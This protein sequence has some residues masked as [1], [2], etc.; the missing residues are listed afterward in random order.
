MSS[1]HINQFVCSPYGVGVISSIRNI[2]DK[3]SSTFSVD[4]PIVI[5]QSDPEASDTCNQITPRRK[6]KRSIDTSN[7]NS[8]RNIRMS[9]RHVPKKNG[10]YASL[11]E[12][13]PN[14][15]D[16]HINDTNDNISN[17]NSEMNIRFTILGV[18]LPYGVAYL[19]SNCVHS[20]DQQ[21]LMQIPSEN[22]KSSFHEILNTDIYICNPKMLFNDNIINFYLDKIQS[23]YKQI[24]IMNTFFYEIIRSYCTSK[25]VT[26]QDKVNKF[27]RLSKNIR[28]C[29]HLLIPINFRKHWSL[30]IVCNIH[31]LKS[32]ANFVSMHSDEASLKIR[33]L[34]D[35]IL[36]N[37]QMK[38][39]L[40]EELL[41]LTPSGE[42]LP[43]LLLLDSA[44]CHRAQQIFANIREFLQL[45]IFGRD[46]RIQTSAKPKVKKEIKPTRMEI[47][48]LSLD[49]DEDREVSFV[50]LTPE[51]VEI[52]KKVAEV[53]VE[54]GSN[55]C[56]DEVNIAPENGQID[57]DRPQE[58]SNIDTIVL[59]GFSLSVPL[60]VS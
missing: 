54:K 47:I 8:I 53:T 16:N 24:E 43:C 33:K 41:E 38:Q 13:D 27:K 58:N 52:E 22:Q 11:I 56:A 5:D 6:N 42:E 60:Q 51:P 14:D 20:M 25:T 46:N 35:N 26:M 45:L 7:D 2:L 31:L 59:P 9:L 37:S 18:I 40:A 36:T 23:K 48:D 32:R 10:T 1:F 17:F 29:G 39:N 49:S 15:D 34:Y 44:K 21:V 28:F 3:D 55:V 57:G 30:A 12:V 4:T 19:N 50:S